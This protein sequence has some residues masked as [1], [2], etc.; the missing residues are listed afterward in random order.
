M[1]SA[2][3]LLQPDLAGRARTGKRFLVAPANKLRFGWRL[4]D[5]PVGVAQISHGT[6]VHGATI[7]RSQ[8]ARTLRSSDGYTISFRNGSIA[9]M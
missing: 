9:A 3:L 6:Q 5:A 4:A 8:F 7:F 1:S 2:S